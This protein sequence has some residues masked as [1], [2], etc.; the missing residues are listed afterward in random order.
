MKQRTKAA[1]WKRD[2]GRCKNCGATDNLTIDHIVPRALGGSSS[3]GNLRL[4]CEPCN[5]E[6]ADSIDPKKNYRGHQVMCMARLIGR[7]K[8]ETV[9]LKRRIVELARQIP[10]SAKP[11]QAI[12]NPQPVAHIGP[13]AQ[14]NNGRTT[15]QVQREWQDEDDVFEMVAESLASGIDPMEATVATM[16]EQD[17]YGARGYI[18][19]RTPDG[20]TFALQL[21]EER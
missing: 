5:A 19:I 3:Q 21:M 15:M 11:Q 6:K 1:I 17:E 14:T 7:L 4:L 12:D 10:S 20:R 13:A 18:K 9:Y 2:E 16:N 8:N